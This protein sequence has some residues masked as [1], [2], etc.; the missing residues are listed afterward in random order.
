LQEDGK[1]HISPRQ[2]PY[3][4]EDI[5]EYLVEGGSDQMVAV[6]GRMQNNDLAGTLEELKNQI[7][8]LLVDDGRQLPVKDA[9]QAQS[10]SSTSGQPHASQEQMPTRQ[11]REPP[12]TDNSGAIQGRSSSSGT[13]INSPPLALGAAPDGT[14]T[15]LSDYAVQ[16]CEE[17]IMDWERR[18]IVT[19]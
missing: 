13:S 15:Q 9:L 17:D 6:T 14:P 8:E 18:W 4:D 16:E 5:G 7:V 1:F 3:S 11:Q 10:A 2:H 19:P 12:I